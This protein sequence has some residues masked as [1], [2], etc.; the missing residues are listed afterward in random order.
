M[1]INLILLT[2]LLLSTLSSTAINCRTLTSKSLHSAS[3]VQSRDLSLWILLVLFHTFSPLSNSFILEVSSFPSTHVSHLLSPSSSSGKSNL[4][5]RSSDDFSLPNQSSLVSYPASP[6]LDLEQSCS[7]SC[8][9]RLTAHCESRLVG[10]LCSICLF[11]ASFL[12]LSR[13]SL[14]PLP[15]FWR[16]T[17]HLPDLPLCLILGTL[18]GFSSPSPPLP[19]S[20]SAHHSSTLTACYRVFSR[21]THALVFLSL[22]PT[23]LCP[24]LPPLHPHLTRSS[25]HRFFGLLSRPPPLSGSILHTLALAFSRCLPTSPFL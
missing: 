2:L 22:V 4:S 8:R 7:M 12:A 5:L 6:F 19:C 11:L 24:P 23:P 1:S 10:L 13:P 9:H 25:H 21:W 15:L 16:S 14:L 3:L 20:C 17:N 18:L